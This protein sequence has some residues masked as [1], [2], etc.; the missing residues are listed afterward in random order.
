MM[1]YKVPTCLDT[2]QEHLIITGCEDGVI[3]LW[4]TRS[5]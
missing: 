2:S 4:D 3:R 1:D 5:G